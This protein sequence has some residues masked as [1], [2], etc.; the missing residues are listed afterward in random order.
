MRRINPAGG[1]KQVKKL[2][3]DKVI[4]VYGSKK[5]ASQKIVHVICENEYLQI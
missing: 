5:Q 1:V 2:D 3:L 4:D